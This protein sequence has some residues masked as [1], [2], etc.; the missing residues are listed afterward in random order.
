MQAPSRL[1]QQI[2]ES[3]ESDSARVV[4]LHI[5]LIG[6]KIYAMEAILVSPKPESA[7]VYRSRLP[8][9]AA[10]AHVVIEVHAEA[11]GSQ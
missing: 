8:T 11:T 7:D 1:E 4:D 2:R 6:P 3:L 9:D 5:W 10:L